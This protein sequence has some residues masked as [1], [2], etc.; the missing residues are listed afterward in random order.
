MEDQQQAAT[1]GTPLVL[2][3][4]SATLSKEGGRKRV[5]SDEELSAVIQVYQCTNGLEH[6]ISIMLLSN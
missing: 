2:A 3:Q 5:L 4:H 1:S 6:K